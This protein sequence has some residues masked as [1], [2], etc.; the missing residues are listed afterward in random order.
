M[1]AHYEPV[2]DRERYLA[3]FGVEP[4]TDTSPAELWPGY[5]GSFIRRPRPQDHAGC[6]PAMEVRIPANVTGAS[7]HRDRLHRAGCCALKL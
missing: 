5:A 6:P 2:T 4:P 1:C 7:G 3:G